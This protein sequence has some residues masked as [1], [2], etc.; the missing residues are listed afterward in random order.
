MPIRRIILNEEC[1]VGLIYAEDVNDY[2][3]MHICNYTH[4]FSIK[5]GNLYTKVY[6]VDISG[7]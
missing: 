5:M 6:T 3:Y 2:I 1:R 4:T 7:W